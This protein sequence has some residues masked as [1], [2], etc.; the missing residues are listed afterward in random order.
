MSDLR[1]NSIFG[2]VLASVLGVM[3]VGVLADS[4]VQS[5]YPEKAGWLPE[6]QLETAGGGAATP[7]G[8]PD[9]GRLFA[10]EAQLQELIAR[11]QRVSAQCTACHTLEAGGPNRIGPNLADVFGRAV[12]SHAGF[13]FSD[14]MQA[15]G[16]AWD[17]FALND[18][19]LSPARDVPGTKM[20]FAGVRNEQDR[21]ALIA[22]LRSISPHNVPLPA[23]F[24][25]AAPAE[26]EAPAE[27][28]APTEA[29][30]PAAPA[31]AG[32][33]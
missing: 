21:V 30:A 7:A 27:G 24:P 6:V 13:E 22:Y 19:L 10:D 20:A 25:E 26:G 5:H 2:A 11:G 14:S 8:P 23:P 17:Y 12:A 33:H 32:G 15:H 1:M 31:P 18:F 29:A 4:V 28:A 9:F 3:G 16:G